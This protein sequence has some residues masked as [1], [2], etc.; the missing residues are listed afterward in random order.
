MGF[1]G[2]SPNW[3]GLLMIGVGL[4]MLLSAAVP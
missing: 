4:V 1:L 2:L 3:L